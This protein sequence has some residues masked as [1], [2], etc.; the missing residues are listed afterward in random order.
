VEHASYAKFSG[1]S[2]LGSLIS[3]ALTNYLTQVVPT[4]GGQVERAGE[5]NRMT[6]YTDKNSDLSTDM[7]YTI[8]KVSQRIP[9]WD[10][11]QIPY[12]DAWGRTES[13]GDPLERAANNL[14]NPA[15]VSQVSVDEVESELQRLYDETG[16]NVFPE[17][18][19]KYITDKDGNRKDFTADE[20][21]A[22]AKDLGQT[23]YNLIAEAT[24]SAEYKKL[25]NG[26]KVEYLDRVYSYANALAKSKAGGKA[27]SGYQLNAKNAQRDIGVSPVK[28]LALYEKYGSSYM[29]GE[30]YEKT[31]K[32]VKNGL[33]VDEYVKLKTGANTDGK[34][35]V[36]KEEAIAALNNHPK[37]VDLWDIINTT[38]ANNPYK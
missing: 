11:Q 34:S 30:A 28:Y 35:G 33:T 18:A 19:T 9:G 5:E 37:R 29:S 13:T 14:F 7:Q 4:I 16:E 23:T 27:L 10:Y 32:A 36:N 31:K 1:G 22:Y 15:Y 26:G 17:R 21:V 2:V 8:G 6:T 12:I 25:A 24:K 38:G 20:Y 3:S